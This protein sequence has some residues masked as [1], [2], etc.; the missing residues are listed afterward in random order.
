V[1]VNQQP[2]LRRALVTS[3]PG[4]SPGD[5]Q[6]EGQVRKG[7]LGGQAES[8]SVGRGEKSKGRAKKSKSEMKRR[9]A[10]RHQLERMCSLFKAPKRGWT[11]KEALSLGEINFLID[12][13]DGSLTDLVPG[14]LLRLYGP[15]AFPPGFVVV[16]PAAP[17]C[18]LTVD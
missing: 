11:R 15:E 8:K 6:V 3:K 4:E 12:G 13:S 18:R 7:K 14:I 5:E 17:G 9:D 10:E 2:A 1:A 16:R